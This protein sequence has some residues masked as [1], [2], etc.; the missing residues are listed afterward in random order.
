[1]QNNGN[2]NSL[3]ERMKARVEQEQ[4]ELEAMTRQQFS[5]LQQSLSELSKNALS[6]TEAA[7]QRQLTSLEQSVT[8][9]CRA[10]RWMFARKWLQILLVSMSILMGAGMGGCGLLKIAEHKATR[11]SRQIASLTEYKD[12]LARNTA[13]LEAKYKGVTLYRAAGK[14]YLLLPEGCKGQIAGT[15]GNQTAISL[16]K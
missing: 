13:E 12:A 6:T 4:Q 8:T 1:M 5:G 7:I 14:D 16:E 2:L 11:L 3:A 10:L 15:V 9:R